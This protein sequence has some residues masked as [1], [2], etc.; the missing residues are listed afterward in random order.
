M[1]PRAR[2]GLVDWWLVGTRVAEELAGT[3]REGARGSR[4]TGVS[5]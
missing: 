2:G 5:A 4:G 1:A 3:G